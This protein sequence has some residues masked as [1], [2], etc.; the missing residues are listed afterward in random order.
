MI[1][2]TKVTKFMSGALA[3]L[4]VM[5]LTGWG[6]AYAADIDT[7]R[8]LDKI[9]ALESKVSQLETKVSM[10]GHITPEKQVPMTAPTGGGLLKSV[11]DIHVGG[12][13]ETGYNLNTNSPN[14]NTGAT[15]GGSTVNGTNTNIRAFDRDANSF[16]ENAEVDLQKIATEAGT[17]G[18]R[19]DLMFGRDAQILSGSTNGDQRNNVFVQQAYVQYIAPIGNGIDIKAGRFVTI[20]GA[21]VIE[22]KDNWNTSRSLL[23]TNAIPFTHNGVLASYKFTDMVDAK[24]GL[25]N[26]WDA[27]V[28][29]N[30]GKTILSQVALHPMKG[31]DFTQNFIVGSEQAR[32]AAGG[33]GTTG[34]NRADRNFRGLLDSVLAWTPLST[35]E[36]W[37]VLANFDYG[38]EEKARAILTPN[39]ARQFSGEVG[40]GVAKWQ[41][42][43]LGTKYDVNNW[44]TLA[45]RVEYFS[46]P[47]GAR[48]GALNGVTRPQRNNIFEM[49]YTAD[50]KLAKNLITRLEWRYDWANNSIF[51]LSNGTTDSVALGGPATLGNGGANAQH[52]LGAEMIYAF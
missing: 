1:Q 20:A 5:T 22:S 26:G 18:F 7:Q 51:D 23:F 28:D 30:K 49:T 44:L 15:V 8:L 40:T 10:Q 43:A 39:S 33:S 50:V 47:E 19:T 6:S 3:L 25:A 11:E 38:W 32:S 9:S 46:D 48:I 37:K 45:G 36:G 34:G 13:I 29:N 21:E 27:G 31:V 24:L 42:L 41:G 52:T 4:L 16:T 12:Y 14:A 17:A 2:Q 35:N